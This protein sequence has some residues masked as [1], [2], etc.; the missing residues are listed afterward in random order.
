[1]RIFW[2]VIYW[3]LGAI[4]TLTERMANW[5]FSKVWKYRN[6]SYRGSNDNP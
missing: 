5:A 3:I 4:A 6:A 1:M 2:E